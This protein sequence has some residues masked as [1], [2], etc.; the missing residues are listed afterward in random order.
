MRSAFVYVSVRASRAILVA[1]AVHEHTDSIAAGAAALVVTDCASIVSDA[2]P[3]LPTWSEFWLAALFLPWFI[4]SYWRQFVAHPRFL[5]YDGEL[6]ALGVALL[7]CAH[8]L[9]SS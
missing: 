5:R 3:F 8:R 9:A 6:L 2:R 4:D 7:A 1:Q